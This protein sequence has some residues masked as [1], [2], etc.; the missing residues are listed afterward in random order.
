MGPASLRPR[1]GLEAAQ[2]SLPLT[3]RDPDPDL[4]GPVAARARDRARGAGPAG[5]L[6]SGPLRL[7]RRSGRPSPKARPC[8]AGGQ[9]PGS[10]R[11]GR[12]LP[13]GFP[14]PFS[15]HFAQITAAHSDPRWLFHQTHPDEGPGLFG[16]DIRRWPIES[17]RNNKELVFSHP[18]EE[19]SP[20]EERPNQQKEIRIFQKPLRSHRR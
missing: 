13:L 1:P 18:L 9:L 8:P 10:G 17:S 3:Q 16:E 6:R 7:A 5:V 11:R 19:T 12:P 2:V 15:R 14:A 20:S 4:L